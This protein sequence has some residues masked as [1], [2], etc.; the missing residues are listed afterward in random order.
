MVSVHNL[1]LRPVER[2]HRQLADNHADNL[3]LFLH[4][5]GV[6]DEA[7]MKIPIKDRHIVVLQGLWNHLV[8]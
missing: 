4:L 2:R 7:V 5:S 8:T 3:G 1:F 6:E